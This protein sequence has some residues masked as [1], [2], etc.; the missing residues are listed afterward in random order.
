MFITS[1]YKKFRF[2]HCAVNM[3]AK[4]SRDFQQT[5]FNEKNLF[6]HLLNEI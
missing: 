1:F 2:T 4:F 5:F 3:R 6:S